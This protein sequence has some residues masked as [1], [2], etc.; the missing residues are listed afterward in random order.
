MFFFVHLFTQVT[1]DIAC[2]NLCEKVRDGVVPTVYVQNVKD[3]D[4]IIISNQYLVE[5]SD[6][7]IICKV[8]N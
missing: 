1:N 3:K 4:I 6:V 8:Y 7:N 5:L 2:K